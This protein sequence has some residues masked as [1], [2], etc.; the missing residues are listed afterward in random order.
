MLV[1]CIKYV[2]DGSIDKYKAC[3]VVRGFSQVEGIDY[4][5]TFAPISKIN[6]IRFLLSLVDSQGWTIFQMDVKSALLHRD[7]HEDNYM[8]QPQGFVQDTYLVCRL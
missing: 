8:D 4:F 5:E 6:Y 1:Y 3:L 2:A 7:L